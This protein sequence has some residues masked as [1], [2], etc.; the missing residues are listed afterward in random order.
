[1]EFPERPFPSANRSVR[2]PCTCARPRLSVATHSPPS[3][4]RRSPRTTSSPPPPAQNV[5]P[6]PLRGPRVEPPVDEAG[7]SSPPNDQQRS[8]FVFTENSHAACLAWNR[9]EFRVARLPSPESV[10]YSGPEI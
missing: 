4:S 2:P 3:R 9:I 1:T 6:P 8:V 5:R 7:D 10:R